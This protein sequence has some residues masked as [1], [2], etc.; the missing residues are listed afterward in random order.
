VPVAFVRLRPGASVD[1]ATLREF[2][3]TRV[4]DCGVPGEIIFVE[5]LPR[6]R[7]GKVDR[8]KLRERFSSA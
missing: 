2:V 8:R 4:E 7:T 5:A 1:A 3:S 6:G